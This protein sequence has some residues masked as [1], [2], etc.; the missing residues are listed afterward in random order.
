MAIKLKSEAMKVSEM[1][2]HG[3]WLQEDLK[4][5]LKEQ[6][7]ELKNG[8]AKRFDW[9]ELLS[10]IYTGISNLKAPSYWCKKHVEDALLE[11]KIKGLVSIN[12]PFIEIGLK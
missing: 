12:G 6:F 5:F 11:L 1:K 9:N 8:E 10:Q 4:L 3:N 2:Q 7:K